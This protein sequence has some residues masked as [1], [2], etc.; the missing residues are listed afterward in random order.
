MEKM[1]FFD[2][3]SEATILKDKSDLAQKLNGR[4]E[5]A[6]GI[7]LGTT[8]SAI[9]VI[10]N[11]NKPEP[12]ILT[13]GKKTMPS[14]VLWNGSK[15]GFIVGEE[16]YKRINEVEH[17]VYSIKR[18]MQD[19]NYTRTFSYGGESITMTPAEISAEILKALVQQTGGMYGEIKDVIRQYVEVIS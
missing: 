11:N 12:I 17:C 13:S 2:K 19:P 5:P 7:D 3:S 6:F 8:N 14:C 10:I 15:Q 16:A 4:V 1:N 18:K 9:S